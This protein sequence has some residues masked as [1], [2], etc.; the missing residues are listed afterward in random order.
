MALGF[1][2]ER[3]VVGAFA[4]TLSAGTQDFRAVGFA[5]EEKA[6]DLDDA[7]GDGGRVED[8]APG[9]VFGDE[10]ASDG[11]YGWSEKRCKA[12]DC[13]TFTSF[14]RFETVG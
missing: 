2:L 11:T 3:W 10:P 4:K 12:V 7:V 1:G 9:G 13:D 14:F 8:P 6:G 5:Q